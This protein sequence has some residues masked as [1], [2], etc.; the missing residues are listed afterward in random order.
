MKKNFS[1]RSRKKSFRSSVQLIL[2]SLFVCHMLASCNGQW[3][4]GTTNVE[5]SSGE[6]SS[7]GYKWTEHTRTASFPK[8]YNFQLFNVYDTLWAFHSAG[9]WYSLNG[10]DWTKSSLTNSINNLAF[11][12]YLVFKNALFGLG[13]FEGNIEKYELTTEIYRTTD[14]KTWSVLAKESNLPKR[15]FITRLYSMTKYGSSA[16]VMA[17]NNLPISG[18]QKTVSTG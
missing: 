12:D 7:P 15:F 11:L 10:K 6:E 2:L 13:H 16:A 17:R 14:L 4:A 5:G 18:I 9:N 1:N 8:G 3:K